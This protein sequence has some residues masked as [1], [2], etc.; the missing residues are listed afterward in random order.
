MNLLV[1]AAITAIHIAGEVGAN[2]GVIQRGVKDFLLRPGAA[3]ESTGL[4]PTFT[5]TGALA[6]VA[7]LSF[8]LTFL[9]V[10]SRPLLNVSFTYNSAVNGLE[11]SAWK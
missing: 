5:S 8:A 2:R 9:P 7:N 6:D 1:H 3:G 4:M 10:A 11:N